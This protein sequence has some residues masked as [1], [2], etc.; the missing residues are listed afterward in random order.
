MIEPNIEDVKK[1]LKEHDFPVDVIVEVT[2]YCNLRCIMCPY[3]D[4]TRSK[5]NMEFSI[6]K[7]IIDE[8]SEVSPKTRVWLAI[9][10]EPLLLGNKL[11][12]MI[13]YAKS[14]NVQVNLNTNAVYLDSEFGQNILNSGVDYIIV[15][16]DG[17][18]E[19]SYSKIRVRGDFNKVVDNVSKVLEYKSKNSKIRTEIVSQ[20]IVMEENEHEVEE[21]K[22]FWLS[23]G[24]IVKV[25]PKLGWGDAVQ[26]SHLEQVRTEIERFPC[27]WLTRT[28]SIHWDGTFSQCDADYEGVYSPGSLLN[29]SIKE[30][31]DNKIAKRRAKHWIGDFDFEPCKDCNDWLAGRSY[32]YHPE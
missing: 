28:V 2:N 27:A 12:D 22:K 15:S 16:I 29:N 5:G 19:N 13:K 9:M 4:L 24:A 21:F 11:I 32:F 8:I 6:F 18:S 1:T 20:F 3:P 17:T 10:G 7:K 31:W 30:I 25:R 14:K 26:A 23:K